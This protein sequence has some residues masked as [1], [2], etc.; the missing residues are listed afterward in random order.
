MTGL[1]PG[2][3]TL[4]IRPFS[5]D[6]RPQPMLSFQG[7]AAVG[8]TDLFQFEFDPS[9][10]T[11]TASAAGNGSGTV[12]SNTGGIIYTY[13]GTSTQTSALISQGANVVL[14]ATADTGSSVSWSTC[15]GATAGNGT[16]MATCTYSSLCPVS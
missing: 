2:T 15:T 14:T 16:G 10:F 3:Y 6:G 11:V 7:I 9:L 1:N 4:T 12:S 13:P 5:Q 8:S